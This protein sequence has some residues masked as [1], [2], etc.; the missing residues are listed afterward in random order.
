[1]RPVVEEPEQP[2]DLGMAS[3]ISNLGVNSMGI[4]HRPAHYVGPNLD[5]EGVKLFPGYLERGVY[6]IIACKTTAVAL[7]VRST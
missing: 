7:R 4:K 1:L 3:C 2:E 5:P 6:A